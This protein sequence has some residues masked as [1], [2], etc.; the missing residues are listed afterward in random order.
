MKL[1]S[2][3]FIIENEVIVDFMRRNSINHIR[4]TAGPDQ[5]DPCILVT[6]PD[7]KT[8]Y[9]LGR[10]WRDVKYGKRKV[11]VR[12]PSFLRPY[13][14][15]E[16]DVYIEKLLPTERELFRIKPVD[17]DISEIFPS[18]KRGVNISVP[19]FSESG[20]CVLP[21]KF[22]SE[23]GGANVLDSFL[24]FDRT[25]YNLITKGYLFARITTNKALGNLS[26]K[27]TRCT[28]GMRAK[29]NRLK[30][31]VEERGKDLMKFKFE[32]T[33][34]DK[35]HGYELIIFEEVHYDGE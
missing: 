18:K 3:N 13:K 7:N 11:Y 22:L 19:Y 23:H 9:A 21:K 31:M 15:R 28:K 4:F 32:M 30:E 1:Q 20:Y 25:D 16:V 5:N 10:Q 29:P 24:A 35:T 8:D 34:E 26:Y 2:K 6:F 17:F 33:M 14:D 12:M 27:L